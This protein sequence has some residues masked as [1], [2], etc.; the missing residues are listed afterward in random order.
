MMNKETEYM[1]ILLPDHYT[2]EPREDGVHCYSS[3][4]IDE[5]DPEHWHFVFEAIKQKFGNK[6]ISV[7]HQTCTNH[8]KFTV[9]LK[10]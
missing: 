1:R 4:G 10:K 9:Y 2:C 3:I 7:Y 8:M 5:C 6:F